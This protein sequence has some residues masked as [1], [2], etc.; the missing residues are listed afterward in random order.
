MPRGADGPEPRRSPRGVAFAAPS[1]ARSA[2]IIGDDADAGLYAAYSVAR[3]RPSGRPR[4]GRS[5]P[6]RSAAPTGRRNGRGMDHPHG[7]HPAP[8]TARKTKKER[9]LAVAR[10]VAE[11]GG[12]RRAV[13]ESGGASLAPRTA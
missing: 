10:P 6:A 12:S 3:P 8:G 7:R 4:L 13:T 9:R 11:A 1:S 2:R 5:T